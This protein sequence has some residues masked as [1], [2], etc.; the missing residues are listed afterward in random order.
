MPPLLKKLSEIGAEDDASGVYFIGVKSGSDVRVPKDSITEE[1]F[2]NSLKSKLENTLTEAEINALIIANTG[3]PIGVAILAT[4]PGEN[5]YKIYA[6]KEYGVYT[7]FP[8]ENFDPIEVF[9]WEV[10]AAMTYL[11]LVQDGINI[12]W[13]KVTHNFSINTLL[14]TD[15]ADDLTT[16]DD[17]KV[18]S[19]AQGVVLREMIENNGAM[20]DEGMLNFEFTDVH[21]GYWKVDGS[22]NSNAGYKTTG[23]LPIRE[24]DVIFATSATLG[25]SPELAPI[26][27]FDEEEDIISHSYTVGVNVRMYPPAGT[28]FIA[29]SQANGYQASNPLKL[30]RRGAKA[31][32]WQDLPSIGANRAAIEADKFFNAGRNWDRRNNTA[33][34]TQYGIMLMGQSNMVGSVPNGELA[35]YSLPTTLTNARNYNTGTQAYVTY[36]V[37]GTWGVWWSLITRLE[38]DGKNV[39]AYFR[40]AGSTG[41]NNLAHWNPASIN[42]SS[43]SN[44]A[45]KEIRENIAAHPNVRYRC[46]VWIQGEQDSILEADRNAYYQNLKNFISFIRGVAGLPTLKFVIVGMHKD[47]NYYNRTIRD[48]QVKAANE[49]KDTYFINPDG[50]TWTH[51]G[52]N[53]H[54]NGAYCEALAPIIFN[55]VKDF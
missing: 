12:Y 53:I 28:K 35:T 16:D 30:V 15:I 7:M 31:Q 47:Q 50:L 23:L 5:A 54:Y 11:W 38:T 27:Y 10:E 41:L 19:A 26:A 51:V 40:A 2:T 14:K 52:D 44:L 37:S 36:N 24:D 18:L 49:D 4:N 45:A 25:G 6:A 34:N 3:N 48:A 1:N 43:H 22:F 21:N 39:R 13:E 55:L 17:E 9:T 46:V 20:E 42:L 8:D 32:Y 33:T 29:L